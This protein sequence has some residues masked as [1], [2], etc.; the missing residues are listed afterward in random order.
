MKDTVLIKDE[1]SPTGYRMN[2]LQAYKRYKNTILPID[3]FLNYCG[4]NVP[5]KTIKDFK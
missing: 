5:L 2:R 3:K 4:M 1:N